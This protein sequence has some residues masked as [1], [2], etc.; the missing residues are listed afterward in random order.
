MNELISGEKCPIM[1]K[2]VVIP[3]LSS[4]VGCSVEMYWVACIKKDCALYEYDEYE[5]P[6][7]ALGGYK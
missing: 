5:E 1:S 2:P 6:Y 7:C 3:P 4:C